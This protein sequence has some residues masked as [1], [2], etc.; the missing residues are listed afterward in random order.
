MTA[1]C[2]AQWNAYLL[3]GVVLLFLLGFTFISARKGFIECFFGFVS[4]IVAVTVAFLFAKTL[5]SVTNGAFGLQGLLEDKLSVAFSKISGFNEDVSGLGAQEALQGGKLP[6]VLAKIV[7]SSFGSGEFPAGSTLGGILGVSVA[8]LAVTLICGTLLFF[9]VKLLFFFLKK[10]L[11]K[12]VSHIK[13][14]DSLN[15]TLGA[16]VGLIESVIIVCFI[17]SIMTLVPSQAVTNYLD[18]SLFVGVLFEHNPL[19]H[20]LSYLL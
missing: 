17:L 18:N 3:D 1:L 4:G 16:A 15:A 2:V 8:K 13:M 11:S 10:T 14:L 9:G 19:V 5:V 20:I 12:I 6:A 7:L